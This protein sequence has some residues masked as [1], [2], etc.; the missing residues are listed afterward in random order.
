MQLNKEIKDESESKKILLSNSIIPNLT[1][2]MF[3][4][5]IIKLVTIFY[6]QLSGSP[7]YILE[8]EILIKTENNYVRHLYDAL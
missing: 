1:T 7:T 6:V 8:T 2:S 5:A 3:Y 4:L